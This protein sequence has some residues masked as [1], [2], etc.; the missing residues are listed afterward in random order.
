M[1]IV[2]LLLLYFKNLLTALMVLTPIALTTLFTFA[3]LVIFDG[4]LNMANILVV[5]LIFGL[6]VDT[7]IHVVHRYHQLHSINDLMHSSTSRAVTISGLTTV[8]T[9]FSLSFSAHKGTASIGILLS[10][11]ISLLLITTFLVLPAL[12]KT[13]TKKAPTV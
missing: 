13:F 3:L 5:P 11:A 9:F 12:L 4:S 10:L 7:G 2:I 8:A 6:G 1:L